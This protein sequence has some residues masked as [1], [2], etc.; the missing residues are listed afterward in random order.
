[1]ALKITTRSEGDTL[2]VTL[3][4]PVNSETTHQLDDAVALAPESGARKI[5]FDMEGVDYVA[6]AGLGVFVKV[7]KA[8]PGHVV[9]AALQEY[10]A[11]TFRL[12]R[13]DR[14]G[15]IC[16]TVEEAVAP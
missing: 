1:M 4:G 12:N 8:A 13:L 16:K 6:S 9:F 14:L 2:V 10:V 3:V 15:K 7:M 5:I 11:D